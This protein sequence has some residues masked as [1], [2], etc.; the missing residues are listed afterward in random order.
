MEISELARRYRYANP[1]LS[2]IHSFQGLFPMYRVQTTVNVLKERPLNV[3]GEYIL[4]LIGSGVVE[5]QLMADVLGLENKYVYTSCTDLLRAG[6]IVLVTPGSAASKL[7]LTR[8]GREA[9]REHKTIDLESE[10]LTFSLDATTGDYLPLLKGTYS[11]KEVRETRLPTLPTRVRTPQFEDLE[12]S[13]MR[14]LYR[15]IAASEPSYKGTELV[16]VVSRDNAWVEYKLMSVLVFADESLDEVDFF[17]FDKVSR[18]EE[19][20]RYL[21]LMHA[22]GFE[23]IPLVH[24]ESM[25]DE[26][27]SFLPEEFEEMEGIQREESQLEDDIEDLK[28]TLSQ[29]KNKEE[30][31]RLQEEL[32]EKRDELERLKEIRGSTRILHTEDHR[33]LLFQALNEARRLVVIVSPWLRR[34]AMDYELMAAIDKTLQRGVGIIIG[35]GYKSAEKASLDADQEVLNDLREISARKHGKNLLVKWVGHNHAKVLICDQRFC[36]VTSFN[37]F[38][39][40]G[41]YGVRHEIGTYS[42]DP[43]QVAE[44]RRETLERLGIQSS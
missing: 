36:V 31:E 12:L 20:E 17:V 43:R 23:V 28:Q 30:I 38:S 24:K 13:R 4:R 42:E 16:D 1:G 8:K 19:H 11:R 2:L 6:L 41:S 35:Y 14:Q 37:W 34:E 40:R 5:P 27:V 44:L 7:E 18:R 39:F 29:T 32:A 9:L 3:I 15:Q 25:D 21:R 26:T 33:P 10:E 22:D